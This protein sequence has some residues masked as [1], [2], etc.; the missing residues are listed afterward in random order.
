MQI[1][2][3]GFCHFQGS[4]EEHRNKFSKF[5]SFK[6]SRNRTLCDINNRGMKRPHE[7]IHPISLMPFSTSAVEKRAGERGE[8]RKFHLFKP[9]LLLNPA[10]HR[11][12]Q[13][14]NKNRKA[15]RKS[16]R[17]TFLS[18]ATSIEQ[19]P[20]IVG[21]PRRGRRIYWLNLPGD[22]PDRLFWFLRGG[23]NRLGGLHPC[24][25][26]AYGRLTSVIS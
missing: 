13:R 22:S 3:S 14:Q 9:S 4:T 17:R 26:F 23:R 16:A 11:Q 15:I 12:K 10:G 19:H 18:L 24:L 7:M 20:C 25:Y 5:F 21:E 2:P 6:G 8:I 1:A